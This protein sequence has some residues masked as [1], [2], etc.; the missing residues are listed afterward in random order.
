MAACIGRD[1]FHVVAFPI[2]PISEAAGASRENFGRFVRVDVVLLRLAFS[3]LA[4]RVT[5]ATLAP[6]DSTG[7]DAGCSRNR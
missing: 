3:L 4:A 5:G 7:Y 6:A 1:A 2:H